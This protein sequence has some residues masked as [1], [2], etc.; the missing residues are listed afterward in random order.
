M[1]DPIVQRV[2]KYV[3]MILV[4]LGMQFVLRTGGVMLRN[5][6]IQLRS[7]IWVGEM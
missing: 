5:A 7:I 1:P 6:A 2:K 4:G 3:G